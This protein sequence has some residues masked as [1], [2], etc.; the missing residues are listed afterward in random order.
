M[1]EGPRVRL[2]NSVVP[3]EER[4]QYEALFDPSTGL[5]TWALLLDRTE[6]AL[7]RAERVNRK[8]AVFAL[9]GVETTSGSAPDVGRFVSTLRA[10]LRSDDT[11]ARV[12]D[13]TFVVVCNNIG[14]DKDAVVVA[15]RLVQNSDVVCQLGIALSSGGDDAP[16][17]LTAAIKQAM[18]T[19]PAV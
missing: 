7:A 14:R 5:P 11:I 17:L 3:S 15:Q 1:N 4:A 18:R 10:N 2:S 19:A 13:R 6:V 16:T 9:E 8:V 12:A